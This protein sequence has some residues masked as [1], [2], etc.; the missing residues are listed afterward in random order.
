MVIEKRVKEISC[1]GFF[2]SAFGLTLR[3][4]KK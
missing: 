4:V 2:L 3:V 1:F